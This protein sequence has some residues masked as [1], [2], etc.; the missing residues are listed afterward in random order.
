MRKRAFAAI[1]CLVFGA[2]PLAALPVERCINLSNFLEVPKDE[3]WTYPHKPEH[4]DRIAEAG[5]D[6]LRLPINAGDHWTGAGLDPAFAARV[7]ETVDRARAAGLFVIVDLHH[8]DAFVADPVGKADEFLDIWRAL[9]GMFAGEDGLAFEL[10]NEPTAETDIADLLPL[11]GEALGVIRDVHP[12]AWVIFGGTHWNRLGKMLDLPRPEDPRVAHT[13][14]YYQ[15]VKFTH[16]QAPW[17]KDPHPPRNWGS[18][19]DRAGVTA[20]LE[21]AGAHHTPVFLGEFGVINAAPRADRLAWIAHVRREAER[22][23]LPW[24][25]WG[26][27]ARFGVFDPD[28]DTWDEGVL[29]ALFD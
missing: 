4:I 13:F 5:F 1:A 25:H 10:L 17:H 2:G 27:G 19:A 28:T 20:D 26:F 9:A 24:C 29:D 12:E 7:K 6:T 16:Q 22:L 21:R 3:G 11:Y 15:P 8:Y 23:G 18:D 14:H